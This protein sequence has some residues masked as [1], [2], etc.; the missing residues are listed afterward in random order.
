M[1]GQGFVDGV[2]VAEWVSKADQKGFLS[3]DAFGYM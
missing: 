1:N 3:L 2:V